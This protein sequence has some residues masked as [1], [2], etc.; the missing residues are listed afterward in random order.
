M[1]GTICRIFNEYKKWRKNWDALCGRCGKC[2]YQKSVSRNGEVIID[3]FAP[4]EHFNKETKLCNIY[5][6]RFKLCDHCGKVNL[7]CVL[8]NRRLPQDCAYA[9]TFR[10]WKK[11][12]TVI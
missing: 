12:N 3:Y 10:V 11:Q 7:F 5:E 6:E 4:C 2:C 9:K 8:F 1:P